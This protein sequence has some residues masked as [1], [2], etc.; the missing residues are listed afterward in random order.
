MDVENEPAIRLARSRGHGRRLRGPR[1]AAAHGLSELQR[2]ILRLHRHGIRPRD[3]ATLFGMS[4]ADV[5]LLIFG[6]DDAG[7]EADGHRVF[8]NYK[9]GRHL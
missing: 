1:K 8:P 9:K 7:T 5:R 4:D 3:L 2:E 6:P